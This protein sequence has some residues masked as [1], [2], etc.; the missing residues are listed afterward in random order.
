[1]QVHCLKDELFKG[2][3]LV[4]NAIS[5]RSTLP[6]LANILVE[7][8]GGDLRLSS[9]DLEVGIRCHVKADIRSAGATT[10]PART[11]S[12]FLRTLED[13]RELTIKVDEGQKMEIRSGKDRCLL[14]GL[15]KDDYPILPEF[16]QERSFALGRGVLKEMI[17][18]T[19]FAV[20]SDE[21]RYVLNGVDFI[22]EKGKITLVATDGRRLAYVQRDI[23]DKKAV[24]NAIIPTKAVNELARILSADEKD[25]SPVQVGF[26]ENQ[27]T[28]KYKDTVILS[29][30]I[31]GHF[32]NFEQVIPK[33]H[34]HQ[35]KFNARQLMIATQRAA[36]G[37]MEKGGS[38][39]YTLSK[40]KLHIS[41]AAMGRVEVE[42]ELEVPYAGPA[43]AIAFNPA[44]LIDV[45]KA[46]E[47]DDVH[48]EL[49][50]PLNP[51]V[52]RPV[53]DSNYRYVLMPMQLS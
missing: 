41:A 47:P 45:L 43:L 13:G 51:G 12:D 6:V 11:L 4:Q 44:Y 30:L 38:V 46:L 9:T 35:L 28:F 50:T 49:T 7:S 39:R 31:E 33:T 16:T 2:V 27:V 25:A 5:P 8:N 20:S 36:V 42:S 26:T 22:V 10:V 23:D 18:K 15:P 21:T 29:R 17:R 52:I 19:A 3:Q 37:T 40:D 1:M 48:L 32:P 24:V 34:E 14:I 53:N